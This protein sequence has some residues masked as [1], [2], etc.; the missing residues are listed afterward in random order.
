MAIRRAIVTAM[1]VSSI[2][3]AVTARHQR[4]EDVDLHNA[5]AEW[6]SGEDDGNPWDDSENSFQGQK[7]NVDA[8]VPNIK[9]AAAD[10][11]DD[12]TP[13]KNDNSSAA[14]EA[15]AKVIGL[16]RVKPG[17][18]FENG[19][20][21]HQPQRPLDV[22]FE[23]YG[24][25]SELAFDE[26]FGESKEKNEEEFEAEEVYGSEAE[27]RSG[28][29]R[30]DRRAHPDNGK[31]DVDEA[32]DLQKIA[33]AAP[34]FAGNPMLDKKQEPAKPFVVEKQRPWYEGADTND[35]AP[36]CNSNTFINATTTEDC[37]CFPSDEFTTEIIFPE[38]TASNGFFTTTSNGFFTT[39]F[40]TTQV[41]TT[42][43]S[44]DNGA[45]ESG[46]TRTVTSSFVTTV[47]TQS[48][49]TITV[50]PTT[51]FSSAVTS[52]TATVLPTSSFSTSILS[53]VTNSVSTI[54]VGPQGS[55]NF[56]ICLFG[57]TQIVIN[58]SST[59]AV[60]PTSSFFST[61]TASPVVTC[62]G[63]M[64]TTVTAAPT[65]ECFTLVICG[66]QV[67]GAFGFQEA[68]KNLGISNADPSKMYVK[69]SY[70][71][72]GWHG[73]GL[74]ETNPEEPAMVEANAVDAM[75]DD[76]FAFVEERS[77]PPPA[78]DIPIDRS[79]AGLEK[80][81]ARGRIR[82]QNRIM[83]DDEDEFD[84]GAKRMGQASSDGPPAVKASIGLLT[85]MLALTVVI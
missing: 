54:T 62:T 39:E 60:L 49:F 64:T 69:E 53:T 16:P 56:F 81:N 4:V 50:L 21:V 84:R 34:M 26:L 48:T 58:G 68:I 61:T 46:S 10:V 71:D 17:F 79:K 36:R 66:P 7:S 35:A 52:G 65:E 83:S 38:T 27:I 31:N 19:E 23:D 37:G 12:T 76:D 25:E 15:N 47:T 67:G 75:A 8:A 2:F 51:T 70:G 14:I 42:I 41:F 13:I 43:N 33:I 40:T 72:G 78:K 3:L 74:A 77:S 29:S 57:C 9:P 18:H 5:Y 22:A 63:A 32:H 20:V 11:I 24:D 59:V 44:C 45:C 6:L 55:I 28:R 1:L 85:A 73:G 30:R 80:N 82:A